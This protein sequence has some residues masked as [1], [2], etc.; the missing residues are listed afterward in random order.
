[1]ADAGRYRGNPFPS[2]NPSKDQRI[3]GSDGDNLQD[4]SEEIIGRDWSDR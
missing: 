2:R 3:V 1:M 4:V